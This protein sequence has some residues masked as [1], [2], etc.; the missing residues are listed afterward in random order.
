MNPFTDP[1][2]DETAPT[3]EMPLRPRTGAPAPDQ[4]NTAPTSSNAPQTNP[5]PTMQI[6]LRPRT[7]FNNAPTSSN[8][9]Q[10]NPAPT[11]EMPLRPRPRPR[12]SAP[13]AHQANTTPSSPTAPQDYEARI[14]QLEKELA[15]SKQREEALRT[16]NESL[17]TE[18]TTTYAFVNDLV[19]AANKDV[20]MGDDD[21]DDYDDRR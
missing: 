7:Q 8:T 20:A 4:S 19:D 10:T 18:K 9:P 3:V 16:D 13:V 12:P 11:M 2:V 5:A 6:P 1:E 17:Q 15:E 21:Y 14:A